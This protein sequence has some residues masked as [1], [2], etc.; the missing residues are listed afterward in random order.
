MDVKEWL[1]LGTVISTKAGQFL[2]GWGK[3]QW[4]S[5]PK[6]IGNAPCFYYP[7]YFLENTHSWFTH[8]HFI[9]I[10]SSRLLDT[11]NQIPSSDP[12]PIKWNPITSD[13]FAETFAQLQHK[14]ATQ[15]LKKAVPFIF[16]CAN[17][18]MSHPQLVLSLKNAL[19]TMQNRK[20]HLYGF[21]GEN[22]GMLGLTP[23]ILFSF[24]NSTTFE[25]MACAGTKS[26]DANHDLLNDPKELEEHR[27]VVQGITESL[28]RYGQVSTGK[29]QLL[30]LPKLTHLLTPISVECKMNT[31]FVSLVEA[32]HPTPALGAFPIQAGMRWL[33]EYQQLINRRRFG[34]PVGYQW[35]DKNSHC[36]VAIRNVQ[37]DEKQMM[38]GAGCGVVA[39]SQLDREW[40]EINLKLQ[41]I[42]DMLAL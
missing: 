25:T 30:E 22:V 28:R 1:K 7:D 4:H 16:Q 37:W 23:E 17:Q 41:S 21:W 20:L 2:L 9:E 5:H 34:A 39:A 33:K 42:K 11:L 38:L 36:F 8:E 40:S 19:K 6:N 31:S 15:E 12:N 29:L 13:F 24:Q 18:S 3:R 32:L 27:L 10:D 14:F 26:A 35:K